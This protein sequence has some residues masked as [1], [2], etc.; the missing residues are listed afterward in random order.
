MIR[1]QGYEMTRMRKKVKF[2]SYSESNNGNI[3]VNLAS[4]KYDKAIYYHWLNEVEKEKFKKSKYYNN[5]D[6]IGEY[7]DNKK[8]I[9]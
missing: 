6:Y 7:Y 5:K 9:K 3:R 4:K 2:I 1:L 8:E